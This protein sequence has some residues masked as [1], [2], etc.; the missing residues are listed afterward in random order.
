M[1]NKPLKLF[2][3]S[4]I[5]IILIFIL[6]AGAALIPK[7]AKSESLTAVVTANGQEYTEISFSELNEDKYI[8]VN[9]VTIKAS[10][11]GVC[12]E[13]SSCRDK[14]CVNTG[15]INS[16]GEAAVCVPMNVAVYIKGGGSS[17]RNDDVDAV[18][19]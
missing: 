12:F 17:S 4:D 10:K 13:D 16:P 3:K 7:Y 11:E 2:K 18:V 1:E 14:I 15:I 19:Y 8:T 6:L 5:I 9:E